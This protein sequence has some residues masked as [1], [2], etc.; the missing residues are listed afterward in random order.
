MLELANKKSLNYDKDVTKAVRELRSKG[1]QIGNN[2]KSI[3]TIKTGHMEI[4]K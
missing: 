4:L 1:D 3:K 2:R